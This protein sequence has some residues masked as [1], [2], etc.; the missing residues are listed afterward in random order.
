M[1]ECFSKQRP[2]KLENPRILLPTAGGGVKQ[3]EQ[4]VEGLGS[5][6]ILCS[7]TH[8]IRLISRSTANVPE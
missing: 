1:Q 4:V 8:L 2:E 7:S 5:Q 3:V 6:L